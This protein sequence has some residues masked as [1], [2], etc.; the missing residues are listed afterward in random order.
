MR[1]LFLVFVV[2]ASGCLVDPAL[3]PYKPL[4]SDAGG[5]GTDQGGEGGDAGPGDSGSVGDMRRVDTDVV[6]LGS[7]DMGR[8]YEP[9]RG[10][11]S[12]EDSCAFDCEGRKCDPTCSDGAS[13]ELRSLGRRSRVSCDG[14][15]T[16]CDPIV[17]LYDCE[18]DC[19]TSGGSCVVLCDGDET[20]SLTC[21]PNA[22]ECRIE[23][24][25]DLVQCD[26]GWVCNGRC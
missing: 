24:C 11:C 4:D 5:R 6:D 21:N 23:G 15:D 3:H 2:V 16:V 26:D 19:A 8:S 17:C 7:R 25:E 13:C 9:C 1:L 20:C 10:N 12:C 14:V 22:G 18:V